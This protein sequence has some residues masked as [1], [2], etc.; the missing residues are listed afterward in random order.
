MPKSP[1]A[2][3]WNI[4]MNSN[5]TRPAENERYSIG[6]YCPNKSSSKEPMERPPLRILST[7]TLYVVS[8]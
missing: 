3:H 4:L 5:G 8:Y 2:D 7:R 1:F 6:I